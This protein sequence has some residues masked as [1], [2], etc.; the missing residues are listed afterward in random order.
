MDLD[1]NHNEYKILHENAMKNNNGTTAFEVFL[2]M[3]V[4]EFVT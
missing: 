2:F 3:Q 1:L 4:S